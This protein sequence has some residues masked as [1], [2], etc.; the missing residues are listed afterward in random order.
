MGD[1]ET[2]RGSYYRR[3]YR[4]M[5]A[6]R[7]QY[8]AAVVAINLLSIYFVAT[9][10]YASARLASAGAVTEGWILSRSRLSKPPSWRLVMGFVVDGERV[11]AQTSVPLGVASLEQGGCRRR[12]THH[13]PPPG[14]TA[15]E[16]RRLAAK[17]CPAGDAVGFQPWKM[18]IRYDAD[19]PSR[20]HPERYPMEGAS[21]LWYACLFGTLLLL[22]LIPVGYYLN[23]DPDDDA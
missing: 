10:Q 6:G 3:A 8:L 22:L 4:D 13:Y 5:G 7:G 14:L 1:G 12:T 2:T 11:E 16:R 19:E 21:G 23:D 15:E 18:A 17:L 9:Q 20:A